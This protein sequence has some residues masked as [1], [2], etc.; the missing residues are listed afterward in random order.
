MQLVSR[1]AVF[2]RPVTLRRNSGRRPAWLE[3]LLM[4]LCSLSSVGAAQPGI[5]EQLPGGELHASPS[6]Y[7]LRSLTPAGWAAISP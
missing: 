3:I 2:Q 6:R 7:M 1:L 5:G 4:A